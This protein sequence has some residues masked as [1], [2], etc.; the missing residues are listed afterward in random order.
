[1][2]V[3]PT[4]PSLH[5]VFFLFLYFLETFFI[6]IYFWFHNLYFYTLPPG[7][8]STARLRGGRPPAAPLPGGRDLYVFKIWVLSHGGPYR[9]ME[10]QQ[11]DWP[12]GRGTA[13][14]PQYKSRGSPTP[15]FAANNIHRGK[16]ERR[17]VREGV[18]TSKPCWI[19]HLWFCR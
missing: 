4:K 11:A 13:G 17:G 6:V 10:G 2:H 16:K 3:E 1:M 14:S 9:P 7:R 15:I 8:G 18:A 19:P 5:C 12:P